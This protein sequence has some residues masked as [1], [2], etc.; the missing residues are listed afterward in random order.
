[1]PK[2]VAILA[3]EHCTTFSA[4]SSTVADRT[5]PTMLSRRIPSRTAQ[6]KAASSNTT[7]DFLIINSF[8]RQ[9]IFSRI[10]RI[11]QQQQNHAV[12]AAS[13]VNT[14]QLNTEKIRLMHQRSVHQYGKQQ[15]THF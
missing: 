9:I 6:P 4:V 12:N 11:N 15:I 7:L 13:I 5:H 14:E 3:V 2:S 10:N 1:L 8:F